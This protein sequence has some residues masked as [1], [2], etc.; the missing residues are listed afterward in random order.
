MA[1]TLLNVGMHHAPL[2]EATYILQR[3]IRT[4]RIPVVLPRPE[5]KHDI[6]GTVHL[7]ERYIIGI[8]EQDK[9]ARL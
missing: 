3:N 7:E 6:K 9:E 5:E 2:S 1:M 4:M 8:E